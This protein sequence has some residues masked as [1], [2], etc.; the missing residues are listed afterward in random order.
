MK[1]DKKLEDEDE[2]ITI[3]DAAELRGVSKARIH[4]WIGEGR[5]RKE[6]R[7]GRVVVWRSEV[8]ELESLPR[9]R[10]RRNEGVD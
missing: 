10:P 7:Y 1:K 3:N 8:M 6:T 2:F 9:G 4:Q 5:L